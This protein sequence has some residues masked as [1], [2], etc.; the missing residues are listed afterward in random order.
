MKMT[1]NQ[2]TEQTHPEEKKQIKARQNRE[3]K[4]KT[5]L[6]TNQQTNNQ[7]HQESPPTN[8]PREAQ[9]LTIQ[10]KRKKE[11]IKQPNNRANNKT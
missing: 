1:S 11:T 7:T 6:P 3:E 2:P 5:N 4:N 10:R 8:Q 9:I